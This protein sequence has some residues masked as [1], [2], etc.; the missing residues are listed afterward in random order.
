MQ[1]KRRYLRRDT[2]LYLQVYSSPEREPVARLVDISAEGAL[3]LSEE[4][5]PLDEPFDALLELPKMGSKETT[6]ILCSFTPRWH[7]PDYNPE[8]TLNGCEMNVSS[9][10][11]P[12][13]REFMEQYGFSGEAPEFKGR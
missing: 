11:R 9:E 12:Q 3:L 6:D 13:L 8:L 10:N 5:F 7:Q 2:I 4:P 1:E